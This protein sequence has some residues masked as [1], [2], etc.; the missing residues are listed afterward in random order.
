MPM[1]KGDVKSTYAD[2][3][4]LQKWSNYHPKISFNEG[5]HIFA[6]WFKDYFKSDYYKKPL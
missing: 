1:Q 4:K 5:I 2:I 6:N 3:E